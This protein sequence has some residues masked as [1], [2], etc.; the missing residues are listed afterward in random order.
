MSSID[1]NWE[2]PADNEANI[3]W[4]RESFNQITP[5]SSGTTYTNFTG[6]ADETA[7]ALAATAYGANMARLAD[8]GAVRSGQLLPVEPEHRAGLH[9][10]RVVVSAHTARRRT[11]KLEVTP[12]GPL[13]L[14]VDVVLSSVGVVAPCEADF[15][16][17]P[18]DIRAN[19]FAGRPCDACR[20]RIDALPSIR[21]RARRT[22]TLLRC[23]HARLRLAEKSTGETNLTTSS[24]I[25]QVRAQIP[26]IYSAPPNSLQLI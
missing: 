20:A 22:D 26:P 2:N 17:V 5:Y 24:E 8:Q 9:R 21:R 23:H 4:V 11:R 7:G 14:K 1:G 18:R 3:A 6:Q 16:T 19:R 25:L 15:T 12:E 10:S 13:P